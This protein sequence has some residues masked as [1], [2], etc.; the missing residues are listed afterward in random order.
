MVLT[1][2]LASWFLF[3]CSHYNVDPLMA[4]AIISVESGGNATKIGKLGEVGLMQ[5]RPEYQSMP[6][7]L[8]MLPAINVM[9]G[10]REMSKAKQ[11]CKHQEDF[12]WVVCYNYGIA[13]GNKVKYPKKTEYYNKIMKVYIGKS[14]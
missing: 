6:K 5:I 8:L 14:R 2:A 10:A 9:V 11:Q 3:V 1:E 7:N 4:S 13:G 12:T